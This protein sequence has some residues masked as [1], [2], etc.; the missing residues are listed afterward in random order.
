[1]TGDKDSDRNQLYSQL[2]LD[3]WMDGWDGQVGW[4][5]GETEWLFF[6]S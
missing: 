3:G 5:F 2:K 4:G 1:M 6:F